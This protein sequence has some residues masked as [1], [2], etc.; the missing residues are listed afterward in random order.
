MTSSMRPT[1]NGFS[2]GGS[3]SAFLRGF[4]TLV[5]NTTCATNAVEVISVLSKREL[6][7][8]KESEV[9]DDMIR[10]VAQ[11]NVRRA[12]KRPRSREVA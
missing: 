4:T 2:D 12:R 10:F 5:S 8:S 9:E 6:F 11:Q 3:N 1:P 7:N